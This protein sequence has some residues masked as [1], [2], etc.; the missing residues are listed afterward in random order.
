MIFKN[1]TLI[2]ASTLVFL[3]LSSKNIIIYNEEILVALSFLCFVVFSFQ[4]FQES[5]QQTFAERKRLIHQELEQLLVLKAQTLQKLHQEYKQSLYLVTSLEGLKS[6]A[7]QELDHAQHQRIQAF[8]VGIQKKC[9]QKVHQLLTL[10]KQFQ[11]ELH[12]KILASFQQSV[13]EYFHKNQPTLRPQLIDQAC[14][15]LKN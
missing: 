2:L 7:I 3:V 5:V 8:K 9:V 1:K 10:E 11:H 4:S 14:A 13:L 12:S 6:A 15:Q